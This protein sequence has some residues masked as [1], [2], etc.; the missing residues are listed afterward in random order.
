VATKKAKSKTK[1]TPK[2]AAK[3]SS[4]RATKR[5][6]KAANLAEVRQDIAN[7]VTGGATG[8]TEAVV[9][10]A[11][12]GQLAP[13][14]YLFEV[15][16]LYPV[17]EGTEAKPEREYLANLL[18]NKLGIPLQPVIVDEDEVWVNMKPA[19][20]K[21]EAEDKAREE[22]EDREANSGAAGD[23]ENGDDPVTSETM[24]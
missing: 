9:G 23:E 20:S 19:E 17:A 21:P 18:L 22:T 10:E 12:K 14:K 1:A 7:I 13:M 8:M 5:E 4:R 2:S 6:T 3:K 15:A 16:G 24:P 11:M